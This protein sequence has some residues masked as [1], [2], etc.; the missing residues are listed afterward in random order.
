MNLGNICEMSVKIGKDRTFQNSFG[1]LSANTGCVPSADVIMTTADGMHPEF[2]GRHP[3]FLY[4][5]IFTK[6]M[7][8]SHKVF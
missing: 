1:C 3:I 2:T 8:T 4:S 7:P 6:Y 5:F